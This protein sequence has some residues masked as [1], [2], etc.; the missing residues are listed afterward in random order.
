MVGCPRR[1]K[2]IIVLP[3]T[4]TIIVYTAYNVY[5]VIAIRFERIEICEKLNLRYKD[6][7]SLK[8][9]PKREIFQEL[10][11]EWVT[12]AKRNNIS[13]VLSS[14]SL[15]GQYRNGDVI[16]WDIDVD[17][18]L[19]ESLLYKLKEIATPRNFVQGADQAFHFVVQ[20]EYGI[21][22]QSRMRRWNCNGQVVH[23]QP[24]HCSFVG[25]IAR[26][27]KGFDFVDIFGLK[28]EGILAYE[29]YEKKYFRVDDLF[30]ANDCIFMEI[31]TKCPQNRKKISSF[32]LVN[33]QEPT[34]C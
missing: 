1:T 3:L 21:K 34:N 25:P 15:L 27:I 33:K 9:N 28:V 16:P 2:I 24:D 26:L 29:G 32:K 19:R 18:L 6:C 10:L 4:L 11:K 8:I 5:L 23:G 30:P 7:D 14:G 22:V 13:Y 31:K 20:P 12:I 17:V